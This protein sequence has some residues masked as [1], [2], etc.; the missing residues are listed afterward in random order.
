VVKWSGSLRNTLNLQS[1]QFNLSRI[2]K[3]ELIS[4]SVLSL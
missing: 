3:D 2:V 4:R 1:D